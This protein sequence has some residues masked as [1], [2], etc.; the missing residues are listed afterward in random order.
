MNGSSYLLDT[1]AV[2]DL[3]KGNKEILNCLK[4]A[5]SIYISIITLLEFYSF[6]NLTSEDKIIFEKFLDRI[7]IIDLNKFN[8]DL[9]EKVIEFRTRYRIKLPDAIIAASAIVNK[10]I[11][12][13]RD[14]DYDKIPEIKII[15][16]N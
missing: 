6:I 9:I 13:S 8:T 14:K 16:F 5:E 10:S 15:S 2:I 4:S 12:I 11:L 1:N 7:H 3:L